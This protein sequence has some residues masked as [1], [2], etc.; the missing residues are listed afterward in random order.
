MQVE[1]V[2]VGD[3]RWEMR[4]NFVMIK[5]FEDLEVYQ[6]AQNLYPLVVEFV[7]RFSK[8]GFHLKDQLCRAANGIQANIAEG[9]GRSPAE[10]K[11]YL[12]RALRNYR[13]TVI[14][15]KRKMEIKILTTHFLPPTSTSGER[16]SNTC[17][18]HPLVGHNPGKLGLIP[19]RPKKSKDFLGKAGRR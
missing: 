13:K 14:S 1:R 8:E 4:Y 9:F 6:R 2:E 7:R 16:G 3:E 17:L 10:F 12:T 11:M 15:S 5:R 18:T 19:D